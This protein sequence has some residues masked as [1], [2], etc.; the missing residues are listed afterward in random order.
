MYNI[1]IDINKM[2]YLYHQKD[3]DLVRKN[4]YLFYEKVI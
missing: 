3:F 2:Y 4:I 1:Y